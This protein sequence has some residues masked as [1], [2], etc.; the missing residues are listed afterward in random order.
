MKNFTVKNLVLSIVI[1]A[2]G[3]M[4]LFGLSAAIIGLASTSSLSVTAS[5][6]ENGF[7]LLSFRSKIPFMNKD[8]NAWVRNCVG[9]FGVLQLIL[10]VAIIISGLICF[11][12]NSKNAEGASVVFMTAGVFFSAIYMVLGIVYLNIYKGSFSSTSDYGYMQTQTYTKAWIPFV[13]CLTIYVAYFVLKRVLKDDLI[14]GGKSAENSKKDEIKDIDA[15]I[16]Y[17][18]LLDKGIITEE[19]FAEK[20]RKI[21]Q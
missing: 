4:L 15:L 13:L 18:E 10:S 8:E 5:N 9:V 3:L 1:V 2:F 7:D 6:I 12:Q 16:K 14:I 19:E 21:L 20:K 17:K 11:L